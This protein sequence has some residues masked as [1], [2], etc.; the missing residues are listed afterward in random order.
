MA[1]SKAPRKQMKPVTRLINPAEYARSKQILESKLTEEEVDRHA[2]PAWIYLDIVI[3][4][5]ESEAAEGGLVRAITMLHIFAQEANS[6]PLLAIADKAVSLLIS[7]IGLSQKRGTPIDL[8]TSAKTAV[9]KCVSEWERALTRMSAGMFLFVCN[10][11]AK[12][13]KKFMEAA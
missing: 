13:H 12:K 11:W 3:A 4:K 8:S 1:K 9:R 10:E 7:A 2:L 6:K 5:K